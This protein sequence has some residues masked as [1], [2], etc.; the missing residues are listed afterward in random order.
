MCISPKQAPTAAWPVP[1]LDQP[2]AGSVLSPGCYKAYYYTCSTTFIRAPL[3]HISSNSG[4][5]A[6]RIELDIPSD[7]I[8][9]YT[10]R[11][12]RSQWIALNMKSVDIDAFEARAAEAERRLALLEQEGSH[13]SSG[14]FSLNQVGV[15]TLDPSSLLSKASTHFTGMQVPVSCRTKSVTCCTASK[16]TCLGSRQSAQR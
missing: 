14:A 12:L 6:W 8:E 1:N 3:L 5:P 2:V 7:L 16:Q 10:I 15:H 9:Y 11:A 13:A 4:E